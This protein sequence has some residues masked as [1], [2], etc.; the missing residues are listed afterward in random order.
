MMAANTVFR[1]VLNLINRYEVSNRHLDYRT[2]P[3][4]LKLRFKIQILINLNAI[5]NKKLYHCNFVR[6][7]IEFTERLIKM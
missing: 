4:Q 2:T 1:S 6:F 3:S 7:F 5:S